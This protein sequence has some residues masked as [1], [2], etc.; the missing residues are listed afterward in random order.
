MDAALAAGAAAAAAAADKNPNL[1][2]GRKVTLIYTSVMVRLTYIY[3][4]MYS[5]A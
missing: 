1:I 4:R 3:Y 5:R 2:N